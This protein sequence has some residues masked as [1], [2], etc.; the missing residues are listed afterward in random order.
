MLLHGSDKYTSELLPYDQKHRFRTRNTMTL[1]A[2]KIGPFRI[3]DADLMDVRMDS[4]FYGLGIHLN[5]V[6]IGDFRALM[7]HCNTPIRDE[8]TEW[9]L[10]IYM[11]KR[12][13]KLKPTLESFMSIVYPFGPFAQ[14]YYL[15]SQDRRAFFERGV[16]DF[17]NDVP[18]GH[19]KVNAFRRWIQEELLGEERPMRPNSIPTKYSAL[20]VLEPEARAS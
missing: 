5:S 17:Y 3:G 15:H 18:K 2:P 20:K 16:Y 12:Q 13:W 1:P 8:I 4:D 10:N 19:E 6:R 11:P 9:T 7:L 14:T